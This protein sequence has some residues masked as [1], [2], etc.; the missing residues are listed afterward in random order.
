[1]RQLVLG[2]P[3]TGKTTYCINKVRE[4]LNDGV[5]IDR[6]CY[7]SFTTRAASEAKSRVRDLV[8]N[9]KPPWFRTIHSLCFALGGFTRRDVVQPRHL[10]KLGL[11]LGVEFGGM[12]D[13]ETGIFVGHSP[14]SEIIST[15]NLARVSKTSLDELYK[16]RRPDF[17]FRTLSDFARRYAELKEEERLIDYTDMLDR[18]LGADVPI[19]SFELLI[20][21]EAQDLSEIQWDVVD[22]LSARAKDTVI[23]GDD[24][25]AIFRWAGASVDRFLAYEADDYRTLKNS[26]RVPRR[27]FEHA[28][29]LVQRIGRRYGKSWEPLESLGHLEYINSIDELDLSTD[30]WLVLFRHQYQ[31]RS[32]RD[33]VASW[34]NSSVR[35]TTIHGAK[36]AEANNVLL[37]C[38]VSRRCFDAFL[39]DPDDE[40]RVFYVGVTRAKQRLYVLTAQTRNYIDL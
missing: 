16:H 32:H 33:W 35:S 19:P 24:D 25:Q 38:D 9:V 23:V 31:V 1:M 34:E 21:D 18:F 8:G 10:S 2:P 12:Y 6:I 5:A 37:S 20:V 13:P 40:L 36:G 4:A 22:R 14:D 3:G 27:I 17:E 15:Y 7:I 29:N 28:S 30:S 11:D 39:E 26:Y